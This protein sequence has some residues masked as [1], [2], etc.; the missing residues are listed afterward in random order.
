[1]NG[2]I[3]GDG[4]HN[5]ESSLGAA[6]ESR[7]AA[8][9]KPRRAP[10][11]LDQLPKD[12]WLKEHVAA[13]L[14]R[15]VSWVY[16]KAEAGLLPHSKRVGGLMFVP[17]QVMAWATAQDATPTKPKRARRRASASVL[18]AALAKE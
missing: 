12:L 11:P 9:K 13:A 3:R 14:G 1:M 5:A 16:K 17:S 10:V 8:R 6:E 4:Q 18:A 2:C 15:S 7:P